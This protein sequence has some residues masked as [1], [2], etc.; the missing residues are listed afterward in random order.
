MSG[1][2]RAKS[3]FPWYKEEVGEK[4]RGSSVFGG[5]QARRARME[6]RREMTAEGDN[7]APEIAPETQAARLLRPFRARLYF[8]AFLV[9]GVSIGYAL[10]VSAHARVLLKATPA[11][12]GYLGTVATAV[13]ALGCFWG[14][15]LSDRKGSLHLLRACLLSLTFGLF[16]G[17][18]LLARIFPDSLAPFYLTSA[19]HGLSLSVFWPPIMREVSVLSPG[20]SLWRSLGAFNVSWAAG[21]SAGTFG[22]PA[23]YE[24]VGLDK[25][26][27]IWTGLGLAALLAVAI[28]FPRMRG[29]TSTENAGEEPTDEKRRYLHLAWIAN[30]CTSFGMGGINYLFAYVAERLG[31]GPTE[32]GLILFMKEAGRF[33]GFALF[34]HFA[35]WHYSLPWLLGMQALGGGALVLTAFTDSALLLMALFFVFGVYG[36]LSY[37]SS[38]YYGLN[39]RS[40]EGKKS[41]IHEGILA[42][43]LCVGPLACGL[44]GDQFPA[45]P[46]V[47]LALAGTIVLAG[48]AAEGVLIVARGRGRGGAS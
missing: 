43:G 26:L 3:R 44:A 42:A 36:G 35:G 10:L 27:L 20:E 28:R 41:A 37:Y 34:G 13:Y 31:F 1:S 11:Q 21:F 33:A 39:L 15:A 9:D 19:V 38:L 40:D 22:G 12:L 8:A 30:F 5:V 25:T 14:G 48:I 2:I 16:P 23:L 4:V 6:N 24:H 47:I 7:V 17:T 45:W 46:G 29:G 32:W 18:M